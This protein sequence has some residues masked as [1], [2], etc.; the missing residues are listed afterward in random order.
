[1]SSFRASLFPVLL[2]SGSFG[3]GLWAWNN[4]SVG[5][6]IPGT[7]PISI[8]TPKRDAPVN[9]VSGSPSLTAGFQDWAMCELGDR[10]ESRPPLMGMHRWGPAAL[11]GGGGG[12]GPCGGGAGGAYSGDPRSAALGLQLFPPNDLPAGDIGQ[13]PPSPKDHPFVMAGTGEV[14]YQEVDFVIPG[15]GFDLVWARTYRSA[16][17][18][19]GWCGY[20]WNHPAEN[21]LV[22]HSSGNVSAYLGQGRIT[23]QYVWNIGSSTWTS[24]DGFWDE[25]T[26]GTR[27]SGHTPSEYADEPFFTKTDKSGVVWEFD[28]AVSSPKSVYVCTS[29]TDPW[30]NAMEFLYNTTDPYQ[31]DKITDTEGREVT[32]TYSSGLMTQL[33]VSN[34]SI[35]TDYGNVTMDYEY[36]GNLLTKATKHKTRQVEGGTVV[37]PYTE[38]TYL[39]SGIF[40]KDLDLVKDCGTTVLNFDY[41]SYGS[42]RDRCTQVTEADGEVHGYS[43]EQGSSP[44]YG[45]YTDPSGQQRDFVHTDSA[46]GN[47]FIAK[48]KE[49]LEDE[50]GD[51]LGGSYDL[52]IT[53]DCDCGKITD[54]EYPD[55]STEEWTHDDDG[56]VTKYV[57][58]S[59][60]VEDDLVKQWTYDSFANHCRMQTSSGWLRQESDPSAKVTWAYDGGGKL[61]T[62]TWPSVTTGQPSSQTIQWE[63]EFNSNGSLYWV[64]DPDD[65]RTEYSY[66]GN[67]VTVIQDP[68]GLAREFESVKDV[69]GHVTSSVDASGNT[70][71]TVT[72]A[73]DGR[74]LKVLGATSEQTKFEYDLR[75]RRTKSS[76]L[77]TGSTWTHTT[78]TLSAG[79][80]TTQTKAD[81]G[82]L[83]AISS[84]AIEEGSANRY[85]QSL[86]P[87]EF[88]SR[89]KWGYGSYG[90]PWKSYHVDDSGESTVTTLTSTLVRNTM[91]R[92]VTSISLGGTETDF[93]Y[94][95]F[96][97]LTETHE[98]LPSSKVRKTISTLTAWGAASVVEVKESSTLLAK[99]T[100]SFDEAVRL[101]KTEQD[102]PDSVLSD[103]VTT[104]LRDK[105][106]RVS[107][108]T[109]P[110]GGVW[111]TQWDAVH[112]VTKTVDPIGNEIQY[113][114]SDVSQTRTI[115]SHEYNTATS[116]FADYVVVETMNDSGRVVTSKNE[117]SASGNRTTSFAYDDA[118]RRTQT[119]TPIGWDTE[120]DY[121]ALGRMTSET[122]EIDG[123][124]TSATTSSTFTL[125]GRRTQVTDANGL[126]T[127]WTYDS[128]GRELTVTYDYGGSDPQTTT[129]TYD[130]YGRLAT[131]TEPMGNVQTF[132]FDVAGRRTQVDINKASSG[133]G[134]PDRLLFTFDD[135]D[136][137]LTGKTQINDSGYVDVTSV[138]R[139]YDGF[140]RMDAETQDGALALAYAHDEGGT[141]KE[142]TYPSGSVIVGMRY[143]LDDLGRP[144]TIERKL[145]T[146]VEGISSSAWETAATV[147]YAGHREVERVQAPYDLKRTQSWTSFKEP[148]DLEYKKNSSPYTLLTGLSSQWNADGQMVVR[149][150]MHD[151]AGGYE[152]GEVFRYDRMGRLTKMW[153]DVRNPSGFASTDPV[154]GTNPYDLRKTWNL[155]KVYERDSVV[156]KEY[157]QTASSTA[158]SVNDHYQVTAGP[159]AMTWNDNGYMTDR[160]ADDFAWTALG[161]LEQAAI[162]GGS[163]LDYTY[164]AFG[165]RVMTVN[166]SQV[167]RF[168]YHGWHMIGEW[169]DTAEEWLWQEAPW[170]EGE[171]M[172]EHIALDTNDLDTDENVSEYRQYAVHED[173]QDTV[174]GLSGTNAAIAERYNYTDPYGQS[175]SEDGAASALGEF[176]TQ[177]FG[178]KRTH[179][180]FVEL[181]SELTDFRNRWCKI[182]GSSWLSQDSLGLVDSANLYQ[183]LWSAPHL[184]VDPFGEQIITGW[185]DCYHPEKGEYCPAKAMLSSV[186]TR[187]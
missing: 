101:W 62:V 123:T 64:D 57:R 155:G 115:T 43:H 54:L 184:F 113:A 128:F 77:L 66:S 8:G 12:C 40:N 81:D 142:I 176:A 52:T 16:Y 102:D 171:R 44:T 134:G 91:G 136:R 162:S 29:I 98:D 138:T 145:S 97:R 75:G 167:N 140:G 172:L 10:V 137:V 103:L 3:I 169:D 34:S 48:V 11:L 179:G 100:N 150:R 37:R 110:R 133:L 17:E 173:F 83:N 49:Y 65:D 79:G 26:K 106:G 96:G 148:S 154:E 122:Q 60:G 4:A 19:E 94:D 55:G 58:T 168:L 6:P 18:F 170:N 112:R 61:N 24:P 187:K 76:V 135:L 151:E 70:T 99:T 177:V 161:Q 32:F 152:W 9:Y 117:G 178:R 185:Q 111:E 30:G 84:F 5:D 42:T 141:V 160:A 139:G 7:E 50:D 46:N 182:D 36:T 95:G 2:L 163:T 71:A 130:S 80:V 147:K 88:G 174:W 33:T 124:P 1:M 21:V 53:R 175:D 35:H 20:G 131:I 127:R 116:S 126:D 158:Y 14:I 119:T 183:V 92:V 15:L 180:G 108:R 45:R 105:S 120:F 109:D 149:E 67:D 31:L 90:L 22:E 13:L 38:Y 41:S 25:L 132:T 121:D 73:P 157:N 144:T 107:E 118:G 27:G 181:E 129:K 146:A 159:G 72:V 82:G 93:V 156:V 186:L 68:A 143:T 78:Y 74:T 69:M 153:Y 125:G 165:R 23:D 86:D 51:D 47:F 164:D 39:S 114:Y 59:A 85:T 89:E 166:G 63:Y 87:D 28:R 56:N 104:Y